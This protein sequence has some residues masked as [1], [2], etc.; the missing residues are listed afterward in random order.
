MWCCCTNEVYTC[1]H[2]GNGLYS[3]GLY[4]NVLNIHFLLLS[5]SCASVLTAVCV[6]VCVCVR[7]C[8][9]VCVCVCVR[10]CVRV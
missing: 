10:V 4:S 7:A 2:M 8:V 6:C 1:R 3:I 5:S 9:C